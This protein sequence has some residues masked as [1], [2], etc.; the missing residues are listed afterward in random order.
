[1]ALPAPASTTENRLNMLQGLLGFI[2]SFREWRLLVEDGRKTRHTH[3]RPDLF[4]AAMAL[5]HGL[6][7]VSR[8]TSDFDYARVPVLN[9]RL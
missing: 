2:V 5:H 8:D 9:P 4:V 1:V 7:V 6:T 3:S